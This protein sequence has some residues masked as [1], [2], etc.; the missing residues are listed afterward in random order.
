[1]IA[2]IRNLGID[3]VGNQII[4]ALVYPDDQSWPP[5]LI[6][7]SNTGLKPLKKT[8]RSFANRQGEKVKFK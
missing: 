5:V 8:V 7:T 3:Y 4:E 2:E 1:M 6:A